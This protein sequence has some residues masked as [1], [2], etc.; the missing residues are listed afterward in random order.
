MVF[1]MMIVMNL[2][3]IG[4]ITRLAK[5]ADDISRGDLKQN[6]VAESNDEI[7]QLADAFQHMQTSLRLA[8]KRIYTKRRA[9]HQ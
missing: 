4:P 8:F 6:I 3:I 9:P 2:V 7:G 5:H 1:V